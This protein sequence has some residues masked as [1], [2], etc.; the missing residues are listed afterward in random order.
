VAAKSKGNS[1]P[2]I[3][4]KVVE[5]GSHGHHGGAWKVAY[6]DFVTA[7]M[8]FFLLLWLLSTS[9]EETLKG[10][11]EYFSE[12][13]A[14]VGPPGGVGG[15]LQGLTV[16]P[17]AVPR[18]PASLLDLQPTA[19][20][21]KVDR[22]DPEQIELG[23]ARSVAPSEDDDP[24]A[25]EEALR[26]REVER[27][28]SAKRA[29]EAALSSAP[30]ELKRL[31]D[32]LVFDQTPE[33]LRI[34]IVDREQYA[35]FPLGSDVMYPHTRRLLAL[36]A[37]A[38]RGMPNRISIRGHTDARPFAPGAGYDNWRL[39]SDRANATRL[40]LVEAGLDPGRIAEVVGRADAEPLV[41]AAPNDPRN[42]R[43]SLVLLHERPARPA[44][45]SGGERGPA[46]RGA[47]RGSL[48]R[49]AGRSPCLP[50]VRPFRASPAP[51]RPPAQAG[52]GMRCGRG[53]A[54]VAAV[55][56]PS[57]A[58]ST[59]RGPMP[60]PWPALAAESLSLP[61]PV[62]PLRAGL[63]RPRGRAVRGT[64]LLLEGRGEFLEK[65][66]ATVERLVE[67][68]LVVLGLDWRGQGG[69][70]RL[71][72]GTPRG[73]VD[74]FADYLEDLDRLV[75]WAKA[76]ALPE[77]WSLLGH[78]LG[79]HLALRWLAAGRRPVARAALVTPMF[80]I[81]LV[82]PPR[83]LVRLLVESA[84]RV[85]AGRHYALG[86][87][88]PQPSCAF[89]G[90]PLTSCPEGFAAA[91]ELRRRHPDRRVGGATWGWLA[92]AL[93]SIE[94]V[95]APGVPESV[96]VPVLVVRAGDE[97]IVCNRAIERIARRLP[98]A[99][100]IDHPGA[101]HDLF[102]EQ[103]AVRTRLLEDLLCFFVGEAPTAPAPPRVGRAPAVR[104][105]TPHGADRWP[106][107]LDRR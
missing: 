95:H 8:A 47:R 35:M 18:T 20:V 103:P 101:R 45:R 66:A 77:P 86:Q 81:A 53:L 16:V 70:P 2:L 44:G 15:T 68:G 98:R 19:A 61:S 100:L 42:R 105:A 58:T 57:S 25:L 87:R 50:S 1:R 14:Q 63:A 73:H 34:Q 106:H 94:A 36:V 21:G 104:D 32:S 79:G 80:D 60:S 82:P 92:A 107:L 97:R 43:I 10:L 78:S 89:E 11:A 37:Q 64:V 71:V 96:D 23:S 75:E 83:P 5:D 7:M 72:P 38:V 12:S 9:S 85:G 54:F 46:A 56:Y 39:S 88:D 65:Y 33:G 13:I 49:R 69:S 26:R 17:D 67:V 52:A 55:G 24:Q 4:K 22:P 29:I 30:D 51:R 6:A 76:L 74:D 59:P 28:E 62:G 27:F 93:R 90:N 48:D 41:P 99:R 84:V 102:F 40:A 3:L 31:K 91:W